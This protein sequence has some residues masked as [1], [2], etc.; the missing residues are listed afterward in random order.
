MEKGSNPCFNTKGGQRIWDEYG[1]VFST[2]V[3]PKG[4]LKG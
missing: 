1:Q 2:E 4:S 3:S